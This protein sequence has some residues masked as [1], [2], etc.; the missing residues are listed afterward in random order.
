MSESSLRPGGSLDFKGSQ[1]PCFGHAHNLSY[2]LFSG[3]EKH[4]RLVFFVPLRSLEKHCKGSWQGSHDDPMPREAVVRWS[5]WRVKDFGFVCA[6]TRPLEGAEYFLG[7]A[8]V[9]LRGLLDR[10]AT[11]CPLLAESRLQHG[12]GRFLWRST[13]ISR[14]NKQN[15]PHW[16]AVRQ[17]EVGDLVN[18]AAPQD[19]S[20]TPHFLQ[21]IGI[22]PNLIRRSTSFLLTQRL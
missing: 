6:A 13:S 19:F 18:M 8:T 10:D 4:S 3:A 14:P 22:S 15:Q 5:T 17:K 12:S 21:Q 1:P 7:L 11:P 9:E 2:D 20:Q 16:R